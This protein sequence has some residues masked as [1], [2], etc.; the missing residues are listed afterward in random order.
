M[1]VHVPCSFG[2]SFGYFSLNIFHC[3][4]RSILSAQFFSVIHSHPN[5][6]QLTIVWCLIDRVISVSHVLKLGRIKI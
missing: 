1:Y 5:L 2:T 3:V 4:A 6:P